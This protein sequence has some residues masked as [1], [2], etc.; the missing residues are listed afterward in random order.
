MKKIFTL[1]R[2]VQMAVFALLIFLS[3]SH[4]KYGIEKAASIDAYCPFGAVESFM[5]KIVSGEYLKR[6]WTSAF[7]LMALT[8]IV[9]VLFGRVFCSHFCPL[10]ALQ[11][12]I[13]GLGRKIGIKK[14]V[15]LPK[16][17]DKYARYLK[18]PILLFI[19]YYSYKVGDLFFRNYDPYNALMHF[20]EEFDEKLY[21]Y[22]ILGVVLISALFSKGWWC[23][24]FCPMGAFLGIVRKISPF[25]IVRDKATCVSCGTCDY[26]CPANLEVMESEAVKSA[27]CIS[28]LNC[29]GDCPK[30]SL[31]AKIFGRTMSKKTLAIAAVASFFVPMLIIIATPFWQTKAPSN[32][33]GTT[34]EIDVANIRGS[35]TLKKV[36]EET[37]VPLEVFIRE[38]G[39]PADIDT[40]LM[41]KEIGTKYDLKNAEGVILETEDFRGVI[42]AGRGGIE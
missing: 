35:N 13:R 10:G 42:E 12:W 20:G 15:E 11:E 2:I 29:V 32:I 27:D 6:I 40:S 14:D 17:V 5:T 22:I 4:L 8:L 31:A 18:Y 39:L 3:V 33:V 34:G 38:L 25:K 21:A 9:T 30:S 23:R 26:V 7:I 24:Y 37:G 16:S 28:C 41:L 36:I 19:I 1:R